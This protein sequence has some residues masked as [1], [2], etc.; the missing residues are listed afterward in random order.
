[1]GNNTTAEIISDFSS[2]RVHLEY[3]LDEYVN[4]D[5]KM[6]FMASLFVAKEELDALIERMKDAK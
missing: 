3:A 4:G 2:L 5:S 1:M 6:S